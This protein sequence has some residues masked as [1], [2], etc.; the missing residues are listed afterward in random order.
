MFHE[1]EL[2]LTANMRGKNW[3]QDF[4]LIKDQIKAKLPKLEIIDDNPDIG[5]GKWLTVGN[6]DIFFFFLLFFS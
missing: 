5:R 6:A 2:S 1:Q 4:E 3:K